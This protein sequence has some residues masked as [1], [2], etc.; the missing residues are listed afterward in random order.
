MSA[1]SEYV[2]ACRFAAGETPR[3]TM[4]LGLTHDFDIQG[5]LRQQNAGRFGRVIL[6]IEQKR[7]TPRGSCVSLIHQT[8][9]YVL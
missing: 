1:V 4:A 6:G 8:E 5:L 9:G 2:P 7:D 3:F